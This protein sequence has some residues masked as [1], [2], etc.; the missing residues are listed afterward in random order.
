MSGK[1]TMADPRV[2]SSANAFRDWVN[3][4]KTTLD[5]LTVLA[6]T[7]P[8]QMLCDNIKETI[9]KLKQ[10][11]GLDAPT[12]SASSPRPTTGESTPRGWSEPKNWNEF[13]PTP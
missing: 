5:K 9:V 1:L 3:R 4:R 8:S 7:R 6:N 2:A 13:W 10:E 12:R 11:G